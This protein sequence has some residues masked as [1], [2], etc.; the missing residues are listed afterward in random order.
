MVACGGIAVKNPLI[1]QCYADVLGSEIFVADLQNAAANG[2]GV[3]AAAAAGLY[4]TLT[5]AIERMSTRDFRRYTP[6][7]ENKP[8]YDALYARYMRLARQTME[9][10]E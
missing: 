3:T 5:D 9:D 1:V 7:P 4:P 6:N 8:A 10:A 2:A